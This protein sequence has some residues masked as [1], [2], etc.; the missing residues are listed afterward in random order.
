VALV[1]DGDYGSVLLVHWGACTADAK[2]CWADEPF[3]TEQGAYGIAALLITR[4]TSLT[5]VERS[6]KGT[7]F[8]FWLGSKDRPGLLFQKRARLEVSG[9][10]KGSVSAVAARM[11]AKLK[12][13]SRCCSP[14]PAYVA[15][16][17]FG[18]PRCRVI[19]G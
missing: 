7:G 8:D 13:V 17:E 6:V 16:V 12:Q 1:V 18:E 9:I 5:V 14:L 4:L 19:H 11:S 3:A 15:V 10:R 2:A